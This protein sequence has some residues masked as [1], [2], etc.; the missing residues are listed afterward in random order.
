M[1]LKTPQGLAKISSIATYKHTHSQHQTPQKITTEKPHTVTPEKN[2]Y[3]ENG[4][5]SIHSI[6][7][8]DLHT[9]RVGA[10]SIPKKKNMTVL[11]Y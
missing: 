11:R 10:S 7:L 4:K 3:I 8:R 2:T 1:K 5:Q 9:S 6:P